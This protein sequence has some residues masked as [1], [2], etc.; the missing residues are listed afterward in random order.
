MRAAMIPGAVLGPLSSEGN[1]LA[2]LR[3]GL[4]PALNP[5]SLDPAC[6]RIHTTYRWKSG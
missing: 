3:I 2:R 6:R 1:S 4:L 5:A